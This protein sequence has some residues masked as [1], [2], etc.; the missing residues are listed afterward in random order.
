M[1]DSELQSAQGITAKATVGLD[2]EQRCLAMRSA[3]ILERRPLIK[4]GGDKQDTAYNI[5]RACQRRKQRGAI[6]RPLYVSGRRCKS[7][8]YEKI[9]GCKPRGR[10]ERFG[11]EGSRTADTCI[12]KNHRGG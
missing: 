11:I 3:G 9:T 8:P 2:K 12:A 6:K 7:Q 4:T 5:A 10:A 1:P